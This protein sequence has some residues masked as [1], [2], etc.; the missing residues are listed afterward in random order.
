[1]YFFPIKVEED[2]IRKY[3]KNT[4]E[5]EIEI[6]IMKERFVAIKNHVYVVIFYL[7]FFPLFLRDQK[8][9]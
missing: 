8:V 1:M 3:D 7:F 4:E 9:Y 2:D 6:H 5:L